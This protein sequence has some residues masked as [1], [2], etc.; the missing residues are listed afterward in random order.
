LAVL[1]TL[2]IYAYHAETALQKGLSVGV[3]VGQM[4][5]TMLANSLV[6]GIQRK[7][8]TNLDDFID[9]EAEADRNCFKC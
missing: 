4:I 2:S 8:G 7:R 9:A 5:G 6:A 1:L 3:G